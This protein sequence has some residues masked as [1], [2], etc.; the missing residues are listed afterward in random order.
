MADDDGIE[1]ITE[2]TVAAQ[3]SAAQNQFGP[4]A[5][6]QKEYGY[7][8]ADLVKQPQTLKTIE[9]AIM[10]VANECKKDNFWR[11]GKCSM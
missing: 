1:D 7:G 11:L 9:D 10:S 8:G 2:A 6:T 3:I 4:S 5:A